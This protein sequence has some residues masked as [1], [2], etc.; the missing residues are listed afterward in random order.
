MKAWKKRD[1][2]KTL[3]EVFLRNIGA[4]SLDDINNW[5]KMSYADE[6]GIR[7]LDEAV[8]LVS[9][10]KNEPVKIIGDY[11][12]DGVTS[13]S[14]LLLALKANGFTNVTYRIPKRFS[15]G[16][17]INMTIIDEISEGLIITCD[18]GI[19]QPE[20]IK[21]AKDKGISVVILDH[22][23]PIMEDGKAILPD[24]DV[25][26][27]P[28]AIKGSAVFN[29]YCGAGIC[30]K[31]AR[32]LGVS[33]NIY[34]M[35]QSLTSLGTVADVMEL[36]EENYVFVRNGLKNLLNPNTTTPGAYALVSAFELTKNLTAH[37]IGFK[38][39]PAIN[40]C[41]RMKDDGAKDA[42]E[43]LTFTDSY[44][45]AIPMAEAIVEVNNQRKAVKEEAIKAANKYIVDNCLMGDVPIVVRLDGTPEGV[46]GIV[47]GNICED[48]KVPAIVLTKTPDGILRGSS[49]SCGNYHM[50]NNLDKVKKY[51]LKYGGH[52]GAAGL[53]LSEENYA[54]FVDAIH[55]TAE[56]FVN[57]EEDNTDIVYYDL[58]IKANQIPD[59]I[60]DLKKFEP[61]GN[62]NEAP[63]F[64]VTGYSVNPKG[65][66]FINKVT[67]SYDITKLYYKSDVVAI[68]FDMSSRFKEPPKSVSLIGTLN[69]NY[70]N[71]KVTHQIEFADF[72]SEEI[73]TV[74]TPLAA[75]L[76]SM[77][78]MS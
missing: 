31:F 44:V 24:A 2:L 43:L 10:F 36:R 70:F 20:A 6:Y 7:G 39:G 42:V 56:G 54:A 26:V 45:K 27:D 78:M 8:E 76:A 67:S 40:A 29:G 53:S 15:E 3:E 58:E 52:E 57:S 66:N 51:L 19:A 16:F 30:L 71:G 62:G 13:T 77:A 1:E 61:F 63:V 34:Q 11:D 38:L 64:K 41:S 75:K 73:K 14:I 60:T 47:A 33:K 65:G 22:H 49:R 72:K 68:G 46:I 9:K 12:V 55:N 25:I 21:A 5:F 17:G 4:S 74:Q 32:K 50:K 48:Y 69:D 28:N 23:E 59:V 18:N 37:D 35:L